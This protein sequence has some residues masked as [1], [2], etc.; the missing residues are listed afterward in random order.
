M[1]ARGTFITFEGCEGSGK[2]TQIARL[3]RRLETAGVPVR[4][5]REPGGTAV[6]EAVRALLLNPDHDGLDA[7]AELLLYE[8]SRAQLVADVIEPAL[9]AGDLVLC[10]RFTDSTTAYQGFARGLS[11]E[12]IIDLNAIATNGLIPDRTI[13]LDIDPVVGIERAIKLGADRLEGESR[14]FHEAVRRGFLAIAAQEPGRVRVVDAAGS[15]DEVAD[16]VARA[17]ADMPVL[18]GA[19]S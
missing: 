14:A 19:L 9:E 1:S 3:A 12:R 4:V 5:L 8:A 7:T 2:S 17:L 10:D 15:A 16:A 11:P 18:A 6:G 13:V